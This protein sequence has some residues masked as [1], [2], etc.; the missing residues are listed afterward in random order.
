MKL[1]RQ[2]IAVLM[3]AAC[4]LAAVPTYT[5][6]ADGQKVVTLGADLSED[7]KNS[8]LR[9]FGIYGQNIETLTIT[10]EDERN[11]LGSYV[12]LEQIGTRTFSCA[13]V[14]PT[15]SGG[16]QV[17]T[18]NLTWVTSNMIASTL[19]TS[20]VVNC[21][22]LAAA[23]FEVSG[24]G[25]LTGILMA[26]ETAVG[27][28]LDTEKKETATQ[29]L[30]TTANIANSIGQVN[31]TSIV[32]ETK[33][34]VIEGN[35][36]NDNDIEVIINE[37]ADEQNITLTDED[38][39]LL[40]ELLQKIAE[41]D[42]NYEDMKETLE[43]VE[44]NLEELSSTDSTDM[45]A[46]TNSDT[47]EDNSDA[48]D[49]TELESDSILLN[50]DDTALGDDVVI[51]STSEEALDAD[52][53]DTESALDDS[54]SEFS[55]TTS[56]SYNGT[57]GDVS[58]NEDTS[59]SEDSSGTDTDTDALAEDTASGS[60]DIDIVNE[61]SYSSDED[62]SVVVPEDTDALAAEDGA[63]GNAVTDVNGAAEE[64]AAVI[65]AD[66]MVF[67]PNSI[68]ETNGAITYEKY[69]AGI[70][71]LTVYFRR[72][73]ITAGSGTMTV[74]NAD[75]SE[76]ETV[77]MTDPAKV[78]IESMT[79]DELSEQSWSEGVKAV[80]YL[81][82]P[83]A[84]SAEY[85]VALSADA[86]ATQDSTA[87]SEEIAS[88]AWDIQTSEYGFCLNA[89]ATTGVYAGNILSGEVMMDGT[90]AGY[91][92]IENMDPAMISFDVTEFTASGSLSV[93]FLAS[94]KTT[95]Q[96]A[97]YDVAGG[98]LL[99]TIDYTVVIK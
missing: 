34:Q 2:I 42:Y 11:H 51:D 49:T 69:P 30:I 27:T 60:S 10:N 54:D 1:K 61:D 17:K 92:V 84:Q 25:A 33:I 15:A 40:L 53:S 55:I 38:R 7:Q 56:D 28:T 95:F 16:I 20:G 8:I 46:D 90:P 68:T 41:Q 65:S 21:E 24:T 13:F 83:L 78:V 64:S 66:E 14:N 5:V 50:T 82:E 96:I 23:P 81:D 48:S 39:A 79:G 22:V 4:I 32:N 72:T 67:A 99:D 57:D 74:T 45:S 26:Y 47:S 85:H 97:F 52:S 59:A 70:S 76:F 44:S 31:A 29:E 93:T 12:P 87:S 18:A 36:I 35:V 58:F 3:S 77:Q 89:T 71:E 80:I 43:R 91:A 75:G 98:S 37:V 86:F 88:D 94:G 19:S 9:Y 6:L 63:D 62:V 73:D